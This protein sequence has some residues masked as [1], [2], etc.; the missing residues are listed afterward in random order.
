M[1]ISL[2]S[3]LTKLLLLNFLSNFVVA[4]KDNPEADSLYQKNQLTTFPNTY[5]APTSPEQLENS[6]YTAPKLSMSLDEIDPNHKIKK[7][8]FL[9]LVHFAQY[10]IT[11]GEAEQIFYFAD[12]NRDDLIDKHEWSDFTTLFLLPFEACNNSGTYLLNK[13]E[14]KACFEADPRSTT[15]IFRRKYNSEDKKYDVM[16]EIISSRAGGD[17][18]FNDYLFIRKSMFGWKECSSTPE[19]ISRRQFR[20]ALNAALPHKYFG[21]LDTDIIYDAGIKLFGDKSLIQNDFVSYLGILFCVNSFGSINQ[22][23]HSSF[24]EKSQWLKS[25][26]E[27][28]LPNNFEESEVEDIFD[29]IAGNPYINAKKTTQ[30]DFPSWVWFF[31]LNRIFNIYSSTR[32]LQINFAE[33]NEMLK[34]TFIQRDIVLGIDNSLTRI[35]Q[36]KYQEASLIIQRLRPHEK[37]FFFSF[38]QDASR[39]SNFS[40]NNSTNHT[41]FH[42]ITPNAANREV[43]FSIMTQADKQYVTRTQLYRA[44][45]LANF[46]SA[47]SGYPHAPMPAV[48][49]VEYI[50]TKSQE[51]YESVRPPISLKQRTNASLY[52]LIPIELKLDLLTFMAIESFLWKAKFP[53]NL[54]SRNIITETELR[55]ILKDYGMENMPETVL[56]TAM[57]GSDSM[58]RREY[59]P[60]EVIK[61]V[62]TVHA[63]AAE[64]MREKNI[65]EEM[66]LRNTTDSS[67]TYPQPE[68]RFLSSPLV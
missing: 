44:F 65:I 16:R 18:N 4:K 48:M 35:S 63:T 47:L 19:Y 39:A 10:K 58:R 9:E 20:C 6:R 26:R 22:P 54:N 3:I 42:D 49:N 56:D 15:I 45:H 23:V 11:R 64:Q 29:I 41:H 25:I 21:Q 7:S 43:F 31:H 59:I 28:R 24:L 68:R 57:K 1:K 50:K 32:P 37:K 46:W 36:R 2:S 30:I 40:F 38:K 55:I 8:E 62:I 27:D 66:G 33:F 5:E 12:Q 53:S 67:R 17:L 61:N 13:V 34:N 52:K 51:M 14:L 60:T